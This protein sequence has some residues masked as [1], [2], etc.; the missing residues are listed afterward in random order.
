MTEKASL[1]RADTRAVGNWAFDHGAEAVVLQASV[2]GDPI[3]RA[4]G[5]REFTRY[6][7]FLCPIDLFADQ[8]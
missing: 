2:Q 1:A 4:M 6:P 3:Y 8:S 7:W 5:Y